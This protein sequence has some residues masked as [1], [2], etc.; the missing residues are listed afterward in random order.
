MRLTMRDLNRIIESIRVFEPIPEWFKDKLLN[1]YTKG[2]V[3]ADDGLYYSYTDD[4]IL[5]H[6]SSRI[7]ACAA[8]SKKC[9]EEQRALLGLQPWK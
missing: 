9:L 8:I 5:S 7:S 6:V 4:D 3:L 2:F 1:V